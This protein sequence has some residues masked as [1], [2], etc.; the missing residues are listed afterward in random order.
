MCTLNYSYSIESVIP[1]I[2][3]LI[4]KNNLSK[5]NVLVTEDGYPLMI[6]N[7][8]KDSIN[9]VYADRVIERTSF[10]SGKYSKVLQ[11]RFDLHFSE[12]GDLKS[13]KEENQI[14]S[15]FCRQMLHNYFK[16]SQKINH[17]HYAWC[18]EVEKS[19]RAHYHFILWVSGHEKK[20]F[21]LSSIENTMAFDINKL[22]FHLSDGGCLTH[23]EARKIHR[24]NQSEIKSAIY[25][26]SYVCKTRGK[27][28]AKVDGVRSFGCS[29]L[30]KR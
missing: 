13:P 22:W 16:R 10:M 21:G 1:L 14:V 17:V 29:R 4:K 5:D 24:G 6:N 25:I 7:G 19:K 23:A 9:L 28:K 20:S 27:Q 15:K 30:V 3:P 11:I 12:T 8:S 18:R 26:A 2:S